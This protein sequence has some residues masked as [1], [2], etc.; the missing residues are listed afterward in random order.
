MSREIKRKKYYISFV[1]VNKQ[2][3]FPMLTHIFTVYSLIQVDC[4][5]KICDVKIIRF[6]RSKLR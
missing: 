4:N 3:L 6:K 2:T 5:N 1:N